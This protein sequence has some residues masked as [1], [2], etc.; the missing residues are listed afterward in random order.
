MVVQVSY[1]G[2]Y[3]EEKPSGIHT[4]TGVST[5]ITAFLG[6]AREGPINKPVRVLSFATF[7]KV[8]GKPIPDVDLYMAVKLF[9]QNGGSD[10]YVVRLSQK[11]IGSKASLILKNYAQPP[12]DIVKFTAKEIGIWGNE[13]CIDIDYN[14]PTPGDTFHV[15][16]L[17]I[18]SDGTISDDEKFIN[19]T[20]D[21][22]SP[23]FLPKLVTKTSRLVDC[24]LENFTTLDDYKNDMI[25]NRNAFSEGRRFFNDIDELK[26]TLNDLPQNDPVKFGVVIDNNSPI[27]ITISK[28]EYSAVT[29]APL[30]KTLLNKKF[31]GANAPLEA[32]FRNTNIDSQ[33]KIDSKSKQYFPRKLRKFLSSQDHPMT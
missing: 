22:D 21:F 2:V 29:T 10:C 12:V 14:T 27:E 18:S 32:I 5:S 17:R 8:F 15:R 4:I 6:Q 33:N 31:L 16:I 19:C 1:P 20:M 3:I 9:F 30:F 28:S 26:T 24:Q 23:R 11:G 13:I 25:D 7:E